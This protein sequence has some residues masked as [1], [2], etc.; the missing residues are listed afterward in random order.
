MLFK[1]AKRIIF[2]IVGVT[3]ILFGITLIFIP[4]PA[5]LVI[6]IGIGILSSE[7]IWAR[8]LI[9]KAKQELLKEDWPSAPKDQA[10]ENKP[11]ES[12]FSH[13]Q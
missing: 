10:I 7:F 5:M 13:K 9:K 4:G 2:F 1:Q 8:R 3:I 6:P 12:T 11:Y